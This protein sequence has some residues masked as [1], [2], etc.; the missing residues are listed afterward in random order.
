MSK[1]LTLGR[2]LTRD[3]YTVACICPMGV[4]LAPVEAML[5]DTHQ[6]LPSS[7]G[8]NCYTLGSIEE[9]NVVIAVMPETGNNI[10]AA[11]AT[12][13]LADFPQVRFGLLV[14]IGGGIPG[15]NNDIRL[16]DVVISKPTATF[17]G[18]VQFDKGKVY[19]NGL[20]ERT[21]VLKK[22]PALLM[23]SV[24]KLEAQHI[25]IGTQITLYM[26]QMLDSYPNMA[27]RG[28]DHPGVNLDLLFEPSYD[29][30]G[31][32]STCGQCD[33]SKLVK[34]ELRKDITPRIHY[35]TIG[36]S[37]EVIKDA[38]TRDRLREDLGILCVETEAAGLMDDFSCL[39]IRGICDY[40][41][42]HKNKIWQPYAAAVAAAYAKELLSIVPAQVSGTSGTLDT[43][44]MVLGTGRLQPSQTKGDIP[45]QHE[46][47]GKRRIHLA[48]TS[49]AV[50]K[51]KIRE[52]SVPPTPLP[53]RKDH[54]QN[55]FD[56]ITSNDAAAVAREIAAGAN[57]NCSADFYGR[58]LAAAFKLDVKI[59]RLL[60]EAGA[61][62][63][64][65]SW[66][67]SPLIVTCLWSG[68]EVQYVQLLLDHGADVDG[69]AE[70]RGGPLLGAAKCGN[71]AIAKC[72]LERGA[73]VHLPGRGAVLES[74]LRF[75][76]HFT[77]RID[78]VKLLCDA[79][80]DPSPLLPTAQAQ[81][82]WILSHTNQAVKPT[83]EGWISRGEQ[84][85]LNNALKTAVAQ[86]RAVRV[87]QLWTSGA[88]INNF[89][90]MNEAIKLNTYDMVN[91]L[92]EL[93][94]DKPN[95]ITA[96]SLGG[97]GMVW[98]LIGEGVPVNHNDRLQGTALS[99]AAR[100]GHAK[101][102]QLL[103]DHGADVDAVNP[104]GIEY[105]TALIGAAFFA[106]EDVVRILIKHGADVNK[107]VD[108]ELFCAL[109][110]ALEPYPYSITQR[111]VPK[112][113]AKVASIVKLLCAAGASLSILSS[114]DRARVEA[115]VHVRPA[116]VLM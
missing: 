41:D 66:N 46:G 4:E 114:T 82:K 20:F 13:L 5:D 67:Y 12:E 26:S 73:D 43:S 1:K 2:R 100:Q 54:D 22:P 93:G 17:G 53:T 74:A 116:C 7:R 109:T 89:T 65:P 94:A 60:I 31:D 76:T 40:A 6:S 10:A 83:L 75:S 64:P 63:N 47:G 96:I 16:G 108:R 37:N 69:P 90:V 115:Y 111:H 88:E 50:T 3:D 33:Q 104:D 14:G 81:I 105:A 87:E 30:V 35:G 11:V 97:L 106:H 48:S 51:P 49:L 98:F 25:K 28:Y 52:S 68:D 29:H 15:Q 72:L 44:A 8:R 102:V 61:N 77:H 23:A 18:A 36:C 113:D 70:H 34:R 85:S 62:L 42:S 99:L 86:G 107:I 24:Q 95:L 21:G 103:V 78:M 58:A 9:H 38:M 71:H 112:V 45:R 110:A 101:I 59:S 91:L 56:A 80:A 79:G 92:L 19:P 84:Q 32:G 57:P 39:V 55:L 27:E